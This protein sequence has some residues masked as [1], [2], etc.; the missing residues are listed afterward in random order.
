MDRMDEGTLTVV[1]P[2][3]NEETLIEGAVREVQDQVFKV[4]PQA[5]LIVVDDGSRDNTGTILDELA[6]EDDR[7][8]IIHQENGGH[9]MALITGLERVQSDFV[10]LIDSDQ[11]MPLTAFPLLWKEMDVHDGVFGV[12]AQR[13]D[14]QIRLLLTRFIRFVI[15]L[16]F[17]LRIRDVNV[18]FKI[19]HMDAWKQARH[20]IPPGTCAP[21]M[22]LSV[23]MHYSGMKIIEKEVPH[24]MRQSPPLGIKRQWS[25]FKLTVSGFLQLLSFRKKLIKPIV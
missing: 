19:L 5:R 20:L 3:Y 8:T 7:I 12:R 15:L 21:S 2:A 11:Q 25:L 10:F 17:G 22:F 9:G 14:P 16:V 6:K 4:L 1:M 24:K 23:F 13:H 18:P